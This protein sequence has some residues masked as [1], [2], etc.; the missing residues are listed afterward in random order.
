MT[1]F[2]KNNTNRN[3]EPKLLFNLS[4]R[5]LKTKSWKVKS[6]P[7]QRKICRETT[8]TFSRRCCEGTRMVDWGGEGFIAGICILSSAGVSPACCIC[9]APKKRKTARTLPCSDEQDPLM[10]AYT[11]VQ[12]SVISPKRCVAVAIRI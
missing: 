5:M 3:G 4:L 7:A 10:E 11:S 2:R 6:C 9:N 1:S 8:L 12:Q